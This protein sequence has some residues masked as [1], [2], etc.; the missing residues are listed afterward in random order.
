MV[1]TVIETT[2]TTIQFADGPEAIKVSAKSLR[3]TVQKEMN[4][5]PSCGARQW[6]HPLAD[7][8]DPMMGTTAE[9]AFTGA[10]LGTKWSD[11]NKRSSFFGTFA[12]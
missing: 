9:N 1:S 8:S 3:L 12:Y 5:D 7:V 2:P 10:A 6:F 4:H 11:P